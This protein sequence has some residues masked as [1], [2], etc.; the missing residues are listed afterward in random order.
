MVRT[1]PSH[2][3]RAALGDYRLALGSRAYRRLW[4][5]A[6]ISRTGDTLN[7]TALPLFVFGLTRSPAAVGTVVFAE[8]VGLIAGGILA[9]SIVDRLP[10]RRLLVTLDL[11]RAAAVLLVIFPTFPTAVAVSLLLGLGTA[12]FAP[13]SNAVVPRLVSDRALVAAN[14]LQWTAGV[15]LQLVAAPVA[16]LLV[17]AGDARLAFALNA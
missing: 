4:L 17:T 7:F 1:E 8:G 14:G 12:S 11:F 15:L 3:L 5:A 10:A 13:L 2:P 16:G 6:V 9:Q